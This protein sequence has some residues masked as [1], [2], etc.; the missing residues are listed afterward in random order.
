MGYL[1][2]FEL[3]RAVIRTRADVLRVQPAIQTT[4]FTISY[5]AMSEYLLF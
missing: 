1:A 5:T 4:Q 2:R 3:S